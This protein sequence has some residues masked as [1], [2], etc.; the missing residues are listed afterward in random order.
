MRKILAVL[1]II[2]TTLC[3]LVPV[4]AETDE[5]NEPPVCIYNEKGEVLNA[6]CIPPGPQ[7]AFGWFPK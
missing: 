1:L 3:L 2:A 6:P 5:D 7:R 4:Y